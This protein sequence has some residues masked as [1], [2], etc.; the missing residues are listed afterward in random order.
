[1][2]YPFTFQHLIEGH[3][4]AETEGYAILEAGDPWWRITGIML[5]DC[6]HRTTLQRKCIRLDAKS[7][8]YT[9]I[10]NDLLANKRFEIDEAW[11][12]AQAGER[13]A[14]R[15]LAREAV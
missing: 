12:E 2:H 11:A 4:H 8:L 9:D 3:V 7:R 6:L 10:A 14:R 5:T 1:M 13:E 15:E